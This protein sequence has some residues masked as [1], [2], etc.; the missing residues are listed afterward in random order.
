MAIVV[1]ESGRKLSED[2]CELP[3]LSSSLQPLLPPPPSSASLPVHYFNPSPVELSPPPSATNIKS[4][5]VNSPF[6]PSFVSA[7]RATTPASSPAYSKSALSSARGAS[8]VSPAASAAASALPALPAPA[9]VPAAAATTAVLPA[10]PTAAAARDG[11]AYG[12]SRPQPPLRRHAERVARGPAPNNDVWDAASAKGF[13]WRNNARLVALFTLGLL[14]SGTPLPDVPPVPGM[15]PVTAVTA[16]A[17][18]APPAPR[19]A[20]PPPALSTDPAAR[21]KISYHRRPTQYGAGTPVPA[22]AEEPAVA[23]EEGTGLTYSCNACPKVF[24]SPKSLKVHS[25][26][27]HNSARPYH[28]KFCSK[29]FQTN[30]NLK[31]HIRTHTGERP[32][33]CT[34]CP[35]AFHTKWNL[36]EHFRTHTGERPYPCQM[37]H[38]AFTTSGNLKEHQ[39]THLRGALREARGRLLLAKVEE[40]LRNDSVSSSAQDTS[41]G[42][43]EDPF[44]DSI[45]SRNGT[46]AIISSD[47]EGG[48]PSLDD[49][50]AININLT[51]VLS[52][53]LAHSEPHAQAKSQNVA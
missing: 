9:L 22:R 15:H 19:S 25:L 27:N 50:E 31:E 35:K 18:P 34:I 8:Y 26:Q 38:K 3:L 53:N 11:T 20:D 30:W 13:W 23:A 12:A 45:I 32:F 51:D 39:R 7:V 48:A 36:K 2:R 47:E 5:L 10:A 40:G 21:A 14:D 44:Q 28:C 42:K 6:K 29:S 43:K 37:C 24:T 33:Q 16:G 49:K 1:E 46:E 17:P 41:P 52:I 4:P